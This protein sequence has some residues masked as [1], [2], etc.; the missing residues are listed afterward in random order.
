MLHA[1]TTACTALSIRHAYI[2]PRLRHANVILTCTLA[3]L[4][5][6]H[7]LHTQDLD[8]A[9]TVFQKM[10]EEL[11]RRKLNSSFG[12]SLSTST[13]NSNS[14]RP[15]KGS[16]FLPPSHRVYTAMLRAC[17]RCK[18]SAS[19]SAT[20][21]TATALQVLDMMWADSALSLS[22]SGSKPISPPLLQERCALFLF[23]HEEPD[24]TLSTHVLVLLLIQ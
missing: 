8:G 9:F 13:S 20:S 15:L 10:R 7:T 17:K 22:N 12:A 21:A 3:T 4:T 1:S 2:T 23:L 6:V 18:S 11:N 5:T 19:G 16:F 14:K 24:C